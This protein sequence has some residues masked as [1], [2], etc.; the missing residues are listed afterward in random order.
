MTET[1]FSITGVRIEDDDVIFDT[2]V[3]F[4][5]TEVVDSFVVEAESRVSVLELLDV[6]GGTARVV[7]NELVVESDAGK[8]DSV[9][10]SEIEKFLQPP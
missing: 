7:N 10:L 5:E 9:P 3:S 1:E 6:E 4:S 2:E 8:T